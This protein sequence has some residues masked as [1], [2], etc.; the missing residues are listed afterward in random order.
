MLRVSRNHGLVRIMIP[1]PQ[2]VG[3]VSPHISEGPVAVVD[4]GTPEPAHL[5]EMQRGLS[6]I[7]LLQGVRFLRLALHRCWQRIMR[8]P[9]SRSGAG[10]HATDASPP[11]PD[12]RRALP[13]GSPA[14][15][16]SHTPPSAHPSEP[17]AARR[18][19]SLMPRTLGREAMRWLSRSLQWCSQD[20]VSTRVR[21]FSRRFNGA[22]PVRVRRMMTLATMHQ[23]QPELQRG[24]A[25]VS[26][27]KLQLTATVP[28]ARRLATC[29]SGWMWWIKGGVVKIAK[30]RCLGQ[31]F[32]LV[33]P[34]TKQPLGFPEAAFGTRGREV[35]CSRL[36]IG[37]TCL[38]SRGFES[39]RVRILTERITVLAPKERQN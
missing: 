6:R 22:A 3:R 35:E 1:N 24:R 28:S 18:T 13:T 39:L 34:P 31:V 2:P 33:S 37:Q 29:F 32:A 17:D 16:P 21:G 8:L 9:E 20:E 15:L 26:A 27:V 12:I 10:L 5:L 7:L 14:G 11:L 36:L 30:I 4:S 23:S 19:T 38:G 25:W